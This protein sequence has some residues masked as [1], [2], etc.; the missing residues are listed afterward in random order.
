[1]AAKAVGPFVNFKVSPADYIREVVV[2]VAQAGSRYGLAVPTDPPR[3][4]QKIIVEFSSP[5]I[6]KPFHAGH[7]RSTIIGNFIKNIHQA[8][9]DEVIA[10]N[11]LGDWGKQYGT[12]DHIHW[13]LGPG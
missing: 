10:I 13:R 4:K 9:G 3:P 6:A 8:L 11:Y 5:N 12:E 7:L 2:E 1:V